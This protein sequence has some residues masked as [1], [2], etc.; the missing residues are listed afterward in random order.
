MKKGPA[1][2]TSESPTPA[3]WKAGAKKPDE[4]KKA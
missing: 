2:Q 3:E 4:P 1:Q